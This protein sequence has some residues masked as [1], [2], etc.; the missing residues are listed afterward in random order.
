MR[1]QKNLNVAKA[2]LSFIFIRY[3]YERAAVL[4]GTGEH[5]DKSDRHS[6]CP[7]RASCPPKETNLN[8]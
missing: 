6:P 7:R 4:N 5:V 8:K 2:S 1:Q 3:L